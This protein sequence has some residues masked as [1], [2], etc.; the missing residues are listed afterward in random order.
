MKNQ[1]SP[2]HIYTPNR[3]MIV[4]ILGSIV[5]FLIALPVLAETTADSGAIDWL[6]LAMGLFGGLAMFLFGMDQMSEGC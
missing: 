2:L 5:L 4:F 1:L 6:N 3:P